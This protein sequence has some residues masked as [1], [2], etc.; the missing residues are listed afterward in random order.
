NSIQKY[1]KCIN[2]DINDW[3]NAKELTKH[4][5]LLKIVKHEIALFNIACVW[6]SN[7]L[8]Q[9]KNKIMTISYENCRLQDCKSCGT[10]DIRRYE[11]CNM[12]I[13]DILITISDYLFFMKDH[14]DILDEISNSKDINPQLENSML[15]TTPWSIA[16]NPLNKIQLLIIVKKKYEFICTPPIKPEG[17][18]LFI[19]KFS[20][21]K[22]KDYRSDQYRWLCKGNNKSKN[23]P[24]L[25]T[26]YEIQ[27]TT[28]KRKFRRHIYQIKNTEDNIQPIVIIHYLG[29]KKAAIDLPHGNTTSSRPFLGTMPSTK[30]IIKSQIR[31][32]DGLQETYKTVCDIVKENIINKSVVFEDIE[33]VTCPRNTKQLK[34]FKY[35]EL[36]KLAVSRDGIF[37]LLKLAR[38][39]FENVIRVIEIYPETN[40]L[41]QLDKY[42][43]NV[44]IITDRENS[45]VSAILKSI[46]TAEINLIFCHNHLIQDIKYWLKSN[47]ATQDDMK[48]D[49][50]N[51]C[52]AFKTDKFAAFFN[53][54]PTNNISES[55]NKM[56]KQWNDWKELPL[57]AL[58][59]SLYKMQIFYVKEFNRCYRN[60]GDYQIKEKYQNKVNELNI[61]T[62][63]ITDDIT[64]IVKNIKLNRIEPK[65]IIEKES[66]YRMTQISMANY[67][68]ENNLIDFS[69]HLQVYIVRNVFS[70]ET[71]VVSKI[72]KKFQFAVVKV[73]EI[74]TIKKTRGGRKA[75]R[76]GDIDV[77][78]VIR[79]DDSLEAD[80]LVLE[81]S[82]KRKYLDEPT[83]SKIITKIIKVA[84]SQSLNEIK[85]IDTELKVK[86]V[87]DHTYF[88]KYE[89]RLLNSK[90]ITKL[91]KITNEQLEDFF[92]TIHSIPIQP[93]T[94]KLKAK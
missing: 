89:T 85:N 54:T 12:V 40:K 78:K 15:C 66:T 17:E 86:L 76:P 2:V 13:I 79:A 5:D 10:I 41:V 49:L 24:V 75:P 22:D 46:D 61:P 60:M 91:K 33:M 21:T 3:E 69:P 74:V 25:K 16:F 84:V 47:N 48:F 43:L 65:S 4:E 81:S 32:K 6:K 68:F 70:S 28:G 30:E 93:L 7:I 73:Q 23:N 52:T 83:V 36:N 18:E 39:D 56:V 67:I 57:D 82:K 29:S 53:K 88:K 11:E 92:F 71:H 94:I 51:R 1:T 34:N 9:G 37:S 14:Q 35:N 38:Q 44:P 90:G 62:S 42:G 50:K 59:L 87:Q 45:I 19:Y 72:G 20:S 27:I 58:V 55:L 77:D 8:D 26:Y 63:S 80:K 64:E 31:S